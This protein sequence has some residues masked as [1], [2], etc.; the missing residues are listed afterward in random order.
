MKW[1]QCHNVLRGMRIQW[2]YEGVLHEG[3]VIDDVYTDGPHVFLI[4]EGDEERVW[5][6][7][8][9]YSDI[10]MEE[11]DP[12]LYSERKRAALEKGR[13]RTSH[14]VRKRSGSRNRWS[15]D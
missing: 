7:A 3:D 11:W 8:Q 12:K 6:G 13:R 4:R 15:V 5:R 10:V 2:L 14:I 1:R 9:L